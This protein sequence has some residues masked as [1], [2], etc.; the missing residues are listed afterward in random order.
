[1]SKWDSGRTEGV[2]L[3][4]WECTGHRSRVWCKECER[5]VGGIKTGLKGMPKASKWGWEGTKGPTVGLRIVPASSKR[6]W[7]FQGGI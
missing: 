3:G 1:M 2:K 7:G 4:L 5:R 6:G